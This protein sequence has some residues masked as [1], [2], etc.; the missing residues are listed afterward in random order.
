MSANAMLSYLHI[1]TPDLTL[2]Y[3]FHLVNHMQIMHEHVSADQAF[4]MLVL[5]INKQKTVKEF[6]VADDKN[7]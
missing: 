7:Y 1:S 6:N 4:V 3:L 2:H 5:Y